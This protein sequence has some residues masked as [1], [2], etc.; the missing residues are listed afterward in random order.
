M[1]D[2]RAKALAYEIA[3]AFGELSQLELYQRICLGHD[4]HIVYRAYRE[5]ADVPL[6]KIKKARRGLFI[7]LIRKYEK[8][9]A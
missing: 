3:Q 8:Q 9:Q 7:Y 4:R 6:S 1:G 5:T 2:D